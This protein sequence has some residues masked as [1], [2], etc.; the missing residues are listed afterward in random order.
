M[1][2]AKAIDERPWIQQLRIEGHTDNSGSPDFNRLLS[3]RRAESVKRW[4]VEHGISAD[5]LQTA[6]YGPSRPIADNTTET[7]RAANRRVDF[8]ITARA[9]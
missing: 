4:L 5:R 6:G 1:A 8:V 3:L 9:P 7:G 2:L